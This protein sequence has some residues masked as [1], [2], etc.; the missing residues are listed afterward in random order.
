M[1]TFLIFLLLFVGCSLG[2]FVDH[3]THSNFSLIFP[4]IGGGLAGWLSAEPEKETD[5]E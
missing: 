3:Y 5:D 2:V 4:L 1:K